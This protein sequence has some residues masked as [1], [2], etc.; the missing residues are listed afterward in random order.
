MNS[1]IQKCAVL[2]GALLLA[3]TTRAVNP[4]MP[5]IPKN[6]F[7]VTDYGAIGDGV[8]DNTTN[9]QNTID[10]ANAAGGGIVEIPTGRYLSGPITLLSSINLQVD[11]NAIL[12]MLPLGT[13][14]GGATN[15]ETFIGCHEVHDLEISGWGKID[16]QGAAWWADYDTNRSLVRPMMLNLYSCDRLFIHDIT[17][18]N[19]PRHHCGLR[20][21][22]GNITI[23]NLTVNTP[24]TSS[25]GV[26][27]HNTDGLNFVGTNSIIEDCHISDGDDNIAMGSS[28]P[29]NGLL[30]TNC[31]FG[32]GHGVSIGSSITVGISNL[33]VIDCTFNGTQNGIRLKSNN[34]RGGPVQNLTYMDITMTNV[35]SPILIY[36]YYSEGKS[37]NVSP[38]EAAG[39]ATSATGGLK[40][41]KEKLQRPGRLISRN[42][43]WH[44]ITFR[45]IM[46]TNAVDAGMIWGQP[47]MLVSNVTLDHVTINSLNPFH[48]YNARGIRFEDTQI[49]PAGRNTYEIYNAE[50]TISNSAPGAPSVSIAGLFS[51]NALALYNAPAS[52]SSHDL[53]GINP[54]TLSGSTL[55][56]SGNLT[57]PASMVLNFM[58]GTHDSLLAEAG[59]LTLNSTL[60]VTA[61]DGFKAGPCTLVS[62]SGSLSGTPVLGSTPR[63]SQCRLDTNT[64]GK[65]RLVLIDQ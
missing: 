2:M 43:I 3:I 17:F 12:Q 48:I 64:L 65:V 61:S 26:H 11:T 16:G 4:A 28:G 30:I 32:S 6:I 46:A 19:P 53:F 59:N 20:D 44:D 5:N 38:Q 25:S 23:S 37:L 62:Y 58:M 57:L 60:N 52:L 15:A 24:Y 50:V 45:N 27:A 8:K 47:E 39:F 29:I 63:E 34:D 14:P 40:P 10:A 56:N 9:L 51:S 33:T 7:N 55:A 41:R 35:R 1:N 18:Q 21:N 31:T 42:P 22:G 13:Y 36:S 49:H 54:L